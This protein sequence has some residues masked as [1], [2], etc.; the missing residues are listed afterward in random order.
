MSSNRQH[1]TGK[2]LPPRVPKA[3]GTTAA[4]GDDAAAEARRAIRSRVLDSLHRKQEILALARARGAALSS[5]A[6][7]RLSQSS[8]STSRTI[9][10]RSKSKKDQEDTGS[11]TLLSPDKFAA[12]RQ[13]IGY[14]P[15]IPVGTVNVTTLKSPASDLGA[16]SS[17]GSR[18]QA[19][20]PPQSQ[21]LL[22]PVVDHGVAAAA[23]ASADAE[24][25]AD[26]LLE[27]FDKNGKDVTPVNEEAVLKAS[28][29]KKK[30]KERTQPSNTILRELRRSAAFDAQNFVFTQVQNTSKEGREAAIY[31]QFH[32]AA[33]PQRIDGRQVPGGI[34]GTL[35]Q[36][37]D[38]DSAYAVLYDEGDVIGSSKELI[39]KK[40]LCG[41]ESSSRYVAGQH[42]TKKLVAEFGLKRAGTVVSGRSLWDLAKNTMKSL[43]KA[44][45]FVKKL[46]NI[47]VE[48]DVISHRVIGYMSGK[49]ED[50]FYQAINNGMWQLDQSKKKKKRTAIDIGKHYV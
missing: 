37:I 1:R 25:E 29:K 19:L 30:K 45:A 11:F 38:G 13:K 18:S 22:S 9:L 20:F 3:T 12:Y 40:R 43:K 48:V 41:T 33:I 32:G 15:P 21:V 47:I 28:S 26:A 35:A 4:A 46:D 16:L 5:P 8:G 50:S 10:T 7:S 23:A 31:E 14:V 34:K 39:L 44:M 6:R 42:F 27:F 24:A 17:P 49:N 2:G 36:L